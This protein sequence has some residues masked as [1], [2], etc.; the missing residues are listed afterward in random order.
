MVVQISTLLNK[1]CCLFIC[2]NKSGSYL[3]ETFDA[4]ILK[5]NGYLCDLVQSVLNLNYT[6]YSQTVEFQNNNNTISNKIQSI[7]SLYT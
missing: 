5:T 6:C 2:M 3:Q 1:I 7:I 4:Q